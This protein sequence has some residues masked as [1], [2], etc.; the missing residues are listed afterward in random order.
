MNDEKKKEIEKKLRKGY[1]QGE[2]INDL[3]SEGYTQEEINNALFVLSTPSKEK[4]KAD[5]FPLWYWA[6]IGFIILG[7]AVLSVRYLWIHDFGYV[8]LASGLIGL[9]VRFIIQESKK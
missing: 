7:I 6:S 8:F 2:L 1:P 9:F 4:S 5:D 3:L